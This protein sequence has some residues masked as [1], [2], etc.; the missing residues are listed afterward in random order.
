MIY[1]KHLNAL[2]SLSRKEVN[3]QCTNYSSWSG[4]L[5]NYLFIISLIRTIISAMQYSQKS[6]QNTT[7]ALIVLVLE[8]EEV[9]LE[10]P[11]RTRF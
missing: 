9:Q 3:E 8:H 6:L 1:T 5:L 2:R 4:I 10:L 7:F 11:Y